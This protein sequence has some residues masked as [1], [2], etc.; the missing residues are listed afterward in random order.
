M[1]KSMVHEKAIIGIMP[2]YDDEK[3]SYWMLPGYMKSLEEQGA[4]PLMLPLTDRKDVLDYFLDSCDGF[5]LTG[6]HDVDPCVY[7]RPPSPLCGQT[8]PLRDRMDVYILKNA[9][10]RNKAVLGIC[11]GIQLMNVAYGGT[12]Y[13]DL[14]YEYPSETEHHM[15]APYDRAVHSV[16]LME[17][18]PLQRL[19][20][21]HQLLV[22]SYHHQAIQT[23]SPYFQAM[24][25]S[26]DGLIEGIYMPDRKFIWGVQWHPEFSYLVS[27][28]SR[29]IFG[30]FLD[31]SAIKAEKIAE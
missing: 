30:A 19:L 11:R 9:V 31:A 10:C 18:T 16:D 7:D 14:P 23:L 28:E 26:E 4:V 25:V 21:S 22:N 2:L 29:K 5:V 27:E 12:L 8:M 15:T 24:A 20:Q 17:N 13:Q 1:C 6:G 3:D